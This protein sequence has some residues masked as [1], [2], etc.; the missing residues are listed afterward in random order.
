MI[1]L[2]LKELYNCSEYDIC[3]RNNGV[4]VCAKQ[5]INTVL[6]LLRMKDHRQNIAQKHIYYCD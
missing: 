3:L 4:L 1:K 6:K 5:I 2:V